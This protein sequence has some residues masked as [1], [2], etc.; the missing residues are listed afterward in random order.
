MPKLTGGTTNGKG[1]AKEP[2][3]TRAEARN[4]V[5]SLRKLYDQSTTNPPLNA[6]GS[7][8]KGGL[9]S[10]KTKLVT[11]G[12]KRRSMSPEDP[13]D[14]HLSAVKT[15]LQIPHLPVFHGG[16]DDSHPADRSRGSPETSS[17][18]LARANDKS[19]ESNDSNPRPE[20]EGWNF[21]HNTKLTLSD[22]DCPAKTQRSRSYEDPVEE[23][24][25]HGS[26]RK[27]AKVADRQ[28]DFDV[29]SDGHRGL[30]LL[31][32][33]QGATPLATSH[34]IPDGEI[35]GK[36][37]QSDL[38]LMQGN[39]TNAN[40][41]SHDDWSIISSSHGGTQEVNVYSLCGLTAEQLE[42]VCETETALL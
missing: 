29:V 1:E 33:A 40:A 21:F 23:D 26:G 30:Q 39:L 7:S 27:R 20:R 42:E 22:K 14:R 15:P 36:H 18:P 16:S 24:L 41:D 3:K 4:P 38:V 34:V 9:C 17:S 8:K 28:E 2:K 19:H 13:A 5:K 6:S 32:S 11:S 35:R 37:S 10:S 25:E 12:E 31:G